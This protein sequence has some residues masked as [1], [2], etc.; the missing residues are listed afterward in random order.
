MLPE[1]NEA[2]VNAFL[3]ANPEFSLVPLQAAWALPS[4]VPCDGPYLALTPR[5]H[6]TDGF[7]GAVMERAA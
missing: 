2:Q 4:P 5:R 7:F 3:A 1:E 6:G